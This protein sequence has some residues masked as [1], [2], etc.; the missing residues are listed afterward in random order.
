MVT[1]IGRASSLPL[2]FSMEVGGAGGGDRAE[3][4][5]R[6]PVPPIQPHSA[7]ELGC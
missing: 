3:G 5:V 6:S 7:V 4:V 2:G 1:H